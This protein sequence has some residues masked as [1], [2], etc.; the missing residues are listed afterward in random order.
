M[1]WVEVHCR[2]ER[3]VSVTGSTQCQ[4]L[5]RKGVEATL[6][7]DVKRERD[8]RGWSSGL[9]VDEHLLVI[10]SHC[11]SSATALSETK[12]HSVFRVPCLTVWVSESSQLDLQ[13]VHRPSPPLRTSMHGCLS[14]FAVL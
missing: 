3:G 7:E 11:T 8:G 13:R 14:T 9:A 1:S 4:G 10:V 12:H 2:P 5:G 6:V